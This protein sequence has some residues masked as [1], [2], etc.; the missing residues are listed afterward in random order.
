VVLEPDQGAAERA[1]ELVPNFATGRVPELAG[2]G[3]EHRAVMI[4]KQA[5][6]TPGTARGRIRL[7]ALSTEAV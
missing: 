6:A 7:R 5:R 3:W 2:P 1:T 4:G